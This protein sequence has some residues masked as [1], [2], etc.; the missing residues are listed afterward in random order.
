MLDEPRGHDAD[1]AL[2]PAFIE[3]HSAP[4]V[5][6][7][8]V[9]LDVVQRRTCDVLVQLLP[10]CVV[11]IHAQPDVVG[12]A[13]VLG[14]QQ[15][16]G[17]AAMFDPTRSVDPGSDREDQFGDAQSFLHIRHLH[18]GLDPRAW[19][20]VHALQSEV[21][22]HA[23]LAG[24][25]NDIARRAH[26]HQVQQGLQLV[27][28]D[29]ISLREA[30]HELEADAAAAQFLVGIWTVVAFWIQHRYGAG[31]RIPGAVVI[32]DDHIDAT[33]CGVVHLV[34]GFDATV[35]GDDE[36][37]VLLSGVVDAL[38]RDA[39]A[40]GIPIR[41]VEG[42]VTG[43]AQQEGIDQGHSRGTIHI[44]IAIDHDALVVPQRPFDPLDGYL[45]V[46]HQEGVMQLF[47]G[48]PEIQ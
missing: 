1:H 32:A 27:R 30:L 11:A 7:E 42:D 6:H 19:F 10:S 5:S 21:G 28:F 31:K 16:H 14:Q 44:I 34:D 45:H 2:V 18:H 22:K 46:R 29:A 9:P 23:V 8:R 3:D 37:H 15:L 33:L 20:Q 13:L 35:Q 43:E 36:A 17:L 26:R 47:Q 48:R 40:F 41:D 24:H 25:R 12:L 39:V 4:R 38:E